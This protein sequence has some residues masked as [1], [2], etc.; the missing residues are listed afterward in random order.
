MINFHLQWDTENSEFFSFFSYLNFLGVYIKSQ[1]NRI[2]SECDNRKLLC[3][4]ASALK[5][6]HGL[7]IAHRDLKMENIL[8][9]VDAKNDFHT[10]ITDFGLAEKESVGTMSG[11]REFLEQ[12]CGTPVY[13]APEILRKQSYS[14]NCDIWRFLYYFDFRWKMSV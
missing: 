9:K 4:L 11:K 2:L 13:M 7:S 12:F 1:N 14:L 6:L 8:V 5:Y 10:K 3:Q